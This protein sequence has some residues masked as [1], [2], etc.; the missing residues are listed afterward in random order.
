[1]MDEFNNAPKAA[2]L[3]RCP[4]ALVN[5]RRRITGGRIGVSCSA[6]AR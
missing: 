5:R 4:A 1:M 2:D 6:V 3:G